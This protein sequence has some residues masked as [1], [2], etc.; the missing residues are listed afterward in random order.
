MAGSLAAAALAIALLAGARAASPAQPLRPATIGQ[1]MEAFW[2]GQAH[3]VEVRDIAWERPPYNAPDEGQGWFGKPMPF[4]GGKW[5]LFNRK[6]TNR[7]PDYCLDQ[8][9]EVVVRESSDRGRTWSNPAAVAA[10]PGPQGAPD[11]CG[12]V[13]G[14]SYYDR[15]SDT[16]HML[17]QCLAAHSAG[18]WQLCH[19][20]RRGPSPI[21]RFAADAEP[22]VRGG[23][24]W[25]RICRHAAGICDPRN[26][27]DEGTPDIVDKRHVYFYVTFH[28]FNY[29]TRQGFRGVA[30]T[31]DFHR[32]IVSGPGLPEAPIF[33]PPECRAWNPGCIG[34][35]EA[36][37]LI[38][39]KY[40]YMMIE[41]PSLSLACTPGQ[42]W[43]IALLR[44]PKNAFPP[45]SSP[46]W[47][48]F[49]A[50]P[51]LQTAWP[52]SRAKC[53][54]QYPRW[55]VGANHTVYILYEDFDY[56]HAPARPPALRRRLLKLVAGGGPAVVL[57]APPITFGTRGRGSDR[58]SQSLFA[59]GARMDKAYKAVRICRSDRLEEPQGSVIYTGPSRCSADAPC[60]PNRTA[61]SRPTH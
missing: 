4:P 58:G 15:A 18:G 56:R 10:A 45:W 49:R 36:S 48:P 43:P 38:A 46:L 47:Q 54:L 32:W 41:T 2:R 6:A 42:T 57:T 50:N 22:A 44:A 51:L 60:R 31:A 25:S 17:A 12:V 23:A 7:K 11:A 55:A 59:V 33:A 61:R 16:W 40:Q 53:A 3:F 35:G 27:H 9:L 24:L 39:G 8:G 29:A 21:G 34:G 30:K 28:G 26:T 1:Q 19:Y 37:T 5:Y 20:T 13:D 14:S 52:S